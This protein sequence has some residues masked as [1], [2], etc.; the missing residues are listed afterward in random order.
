MSICLM[1]VVRDVEGSK[2]QRLN[3]R[4]S[5][6]SS[7]LSVGGAAAIAVRP[8]C[9]KPCPSETEAWPYSVM[10]EAPVRR[11]RLLYALNGARERRTVHVVCLLGPME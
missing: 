6:K 8:V 5:V 9:C 2:P 7:L 11:Q 4:R 3:A 1:R 10:D